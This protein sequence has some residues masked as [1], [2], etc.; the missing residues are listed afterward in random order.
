[1]PVLREKLTP[2]FELGC[3][4]LIFSDVFYDAIQHPNVELVTDTIECIE[5]AGVRTKDGRLH[6]LDVLVTA[7][8]FHALDYTRDM[9]ITGENGVNLGERWEREG[10]QALRSIAIAGFP[11]L[12][13][14]IGPHSPI[15]NFSLTGIAEI[16]IKYIMQFIRMLKKGEV[17]AVAA[18]AVAQ[19]KYNDRIR[20]GF[21]GTTW[22]TGC[23]SWYLDTKTNMPRMYPFTPNQF[24]QDMR[25]VDLTE[26]ELGN[27]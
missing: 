16:Q 10:A 20:H 22:V 23:T 13:M 11:N 7:T 8:G 17:K 25:E 1:D 18:K 3:R 9:I 4:R 2:K 14:L 24:R 21:Q 5:P 27:A 15:G 19:E 6:E 12:F 26:F